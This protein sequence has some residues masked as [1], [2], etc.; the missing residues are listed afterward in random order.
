MPWFLVASIFGL[1]AGSLF[2]A[3]VD[4]D[5][6]AAHIYGY[7]VLLAFGA[8]LSQQAA[9]SVAPTEVQPHR[10][11]DAVGFI[12]MAQIGSSVIALTITSS[13]FQNVGFRH[14]STALDG[15]G[16][17]ADEVHAALAGQRSAIFTQVSDEV[18][19]QLIKAIL[20]TVNDEYILVIAAGAL[21][22]IVSMLMSRAKLN[23]EMASGG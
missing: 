3:A 20:V 11:P 19:Q 18:R 22:T 12:N 14:V 13:V 6:P 21:G 16:Y 4:V 15:L 5:T 7:S 9:Y 23:M 1:I 2:Y 8:G 10:I 17:T